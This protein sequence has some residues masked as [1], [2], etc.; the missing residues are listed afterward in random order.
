MC[1]VPGQGPIWLGV[2]W[3]CEKALGGPEGRSVG[4]TEASV[5]WEEATDEAQRWLRSHY[6]QSSL[7][8]WVRACAG[9]LPSQMGSSSLGLAQVWEV[10]E[11]KEETVG[12]NGLLS[13]FVL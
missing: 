11:L 3:A 13:S 6:P 10:R 5:T 1:L 9:Q 4:H 7:T 8:W 12:K 2:G